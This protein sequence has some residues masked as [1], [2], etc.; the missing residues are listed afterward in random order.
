MSQHGQHE[1][2]ENANAGFYGVAPTVAG[3]LIGFTLIVFMFL[4]ADGFS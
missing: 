3:I 1:D 4:V 2:D